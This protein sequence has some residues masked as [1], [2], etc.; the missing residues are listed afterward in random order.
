MSFGKFGN[1]KC[2]RVC[3]AFGDLDGR[4]MQ[5]W[6]IFGKSD[7]DFFLALGK[8]DDVSLKD[9]IEDVG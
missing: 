7:F 4:G 9:C 2:A 6:G 5:F 3:A 8:C 1:A